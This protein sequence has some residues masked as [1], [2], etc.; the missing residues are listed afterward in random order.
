[1]FTST[2]T[3]TLPRQPAAT[4]VVDTMGEPLINPQTLG[5]NFNTPRAN[6][7][8]PRANL[9]IPPHLRDVR[10]RQQQLVTTKKRQPRGRGGPTMQSSSHP[11][12]RTL[13]TENQMVMS[14]IHVQADLAPTPG[15]P[16]QTAPTC[17]NPSGN[18][19]RSQ[20]TE[21]ELK[22]KE[23]SLKNRET[24]VRR[25]ENKV[26]EVSDQVVALREL[27][28]RLELRNNTLQDENN[29]LKIKLQ[30]SG[31]LP[32]R[33]QPDPQLPQKTPTCC[34]KPPPP[35]IQLGGTATCP[36]QNVISDE[37]LVRILDR[38]NC[39]QSC[40][41]SSTQ[42]AALAETLVQALERANGALIHHTFQMLQQTVNK[43]G[44]VPPKQS[45]MES[46]PPQHWRN[47]RVPSRGR[48]PQGK[49]LCSPTSPGHATTQTKNIRE[50]PWACCNRC[51]KG[52]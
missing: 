35:D 18:I 1:M 29:L 17:D 32:S 15:A 3:A 52:N 24:A 22:A 9:Y 44:A 46:R 47:S 25:Q 20:V 7:N 6:S 33:T 37:A 31:P 43:H 5:A 45:G 4:S 21:Q 11:N 39:R 30:A 19:G 40:P 38:T 48:R 36:A 13:R 50:Q 26:R 42:T 2:T 34:Y 41:D 49:G 16:I 10:H 8:T 28:T 14:T 23:R 27:V 51:K 12:P